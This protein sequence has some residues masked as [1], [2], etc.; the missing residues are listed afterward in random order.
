MKKNLVALA[1]CLSLFTVKASLTKSGTLSNYCETQ[2]GN[3]LNISFRC[4]PSTD[5][6]FRVVGDCL[7]INCGRSF[8]TSQEPVYDPAND[9][10]TLEL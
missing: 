4:M 2:D 1:L 10:Y 7:Y 9:L 6:C 5:W 8:P 3:S